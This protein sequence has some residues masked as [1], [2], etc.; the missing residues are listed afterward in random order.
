M[1]GHPHG[2]TTSSIQSSAS[3]HIS[4][5]TS[6]WSTHQ[7]SLQQSYSIPH[8]LVTPTSRR[9]HQCIWDTVGL[10]QTDLVCVSETI[11]WRALRRNGGLNRGSCAAMWL[12]PQIFII[13]FWLISFFHAIVYLLGSELGLL[14]ATS[15]YLEFML[16][17]MRWCPALIQSVLV[18]F[19]PHAL[20]TLQ[21]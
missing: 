12:S 3:S 5:L 13:V 1:W 4:P 15:K 14:F 20:T 11:E 6:L 8:I 16:Q 2:S 18:T 9:G 10:L 21:I 17:Q 7:I 19:P